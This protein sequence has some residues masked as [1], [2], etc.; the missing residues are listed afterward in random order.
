MPLISS[1]SYDS[2]SAIAS[3]PTATEYGLDDVQSFAVLR[4]VTRPL[5]PVPL[6]FAATPHPC[7][8]DLAGVRIGARC[9][10]M[11]RAIEDPAAPLHVL[12]WWWDLGGGG[13]HVVGARDAEEEK[14]WT[15]E[16]DAGGNRVAA[17]PI[18]LVPPRTLSGGV[19]LR[20]I[21]WQTP[22]PASE[23]TAAVG[24]AMRHTKLNGVLDLLGGGSTTMHTVGLVREAAAAL[25]GEI[26]PVLRGLCTDYLDFFEGLYPTAAL[27]DTEWTAEGYDSDLRVRGRAG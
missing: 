23:V 27:S 17:G 5:Q 22:V 16:L 3:G 6:T 4:E 1:G 20:V 15:L 2:F 13:P 11:M 18:P 25:G 24:E 12:A 21:L 9:R 14:R 7:G 10:V 19:A 8:L 26:A